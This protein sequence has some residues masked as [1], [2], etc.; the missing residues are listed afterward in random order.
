MGKLIES[1]VTPREKWMEFVQRKSINNERFIYMEATRT[2]QLFKTDLEQIYR[3]QHMTLRKIAR[4]NNRD[5]K[6]LLEF[7][8]SYEEDFVI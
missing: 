8:G 5:F 3:T 4:L 7:K 6:E 1:S 2:Y